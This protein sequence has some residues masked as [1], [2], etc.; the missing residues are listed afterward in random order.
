MTPPTFSPM[1]QIILEYEGFDAFLIPSSYRRKCIT[2]Y[3]DNE[4]Q[5]VKGVISFFIPEIGDPIAPNAAQKFIVDFKEDKINFQ[6]VKFKVLD[7]TGHVS[8]Y[9]EHVLEQK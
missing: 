4:T 3:R 6:Q 8:H 2:L 7:S 5:T 9:L 1:G